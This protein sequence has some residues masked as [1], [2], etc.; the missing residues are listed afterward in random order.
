MAV[1][2][3]ESTKVSGANRATLYTRIENNRTERLIEWGGSYY[4]IGGTTGNLTLTPTAVNTATLQ[5]DTTLSN[6][7]IVYKDGGN[8]YIKDDNN[9]S[10]YSVR[11]DSATNNGLSTVTYNLNVEAGTL[12]GGNSSN[13]E[14]GTIDLNTAR[15]LLN[16]KVQVYTPSSTTLGT[17]NNTPVVYLAFR[18]NNTD[19]IYGYNTG[20]NTLSFIGN[21]LPAGVTVTQ[22]FSGKS[23]QVISDNNGKVYLYADGTVSEPDWQ[24]NTLV[25]VTK[26]TTNGTTGM[27]G[28]I[29]NNNILNTIGGV[30]DSL[31]SSSTI[32][33]NN[34]GSDPQYTV[35]KI[36]YSKDGTWTGLI[37][38]VPEVG[39]GSVLFYDPSTGRL[40]SQAPFADLRASIQNNGLKAELFFQNQGIVPLNDGRIAF[41][42]E[43]SN[44]PV[45]LGLDPNGQPIIQ[46]VNTGFVGDSS[47]GNNTTIVNGMNT[48][49]DNPYVTLASAAAWAPTELKNVQ[50]YVELFASAVLA[51]QSLVKIVN[52]ND[53]NT[54]PLNP[55]TLNPNTL[56]TGIPDFLPP[57]KNNGNTTTQGSSQQTGSSGNDAL[58]TPA[59]LP[60]V[61]SVLA[62]N[63]VESDPE[64]TNPAQ[65]PAASTPAATPTPTPKP[66]PAA[67]TPETKQN[68]NNNKQTVAAASESKTKQTGNVVQNPG[69]GG[70]RSNNNVMAGTNSGNKNEKVDKGTL[71]LDTNDSKNPLEIRFTLDG[72][73]LTANQ[74]KIEDNNVVIQVGKNTGDRI[75]TIPLSGISAVNLAGLGGTLENKYIVKQPVTG[76][77]DQYFTLT[78]A[79]ISSYKLTA[80]GSKPPL[81]GGT[82][83]FDIDGDGKAE[84]TDPINL[85]WAIKN[86][87]PSSSSET[88]NQ[89]KKTTSP[90]E[91]RM[92]PSSP[93]RENFDFFWEVRSPGKK[94]ATLVLMAK[95]KSANTSKPV[96][97]LVK[98]GNIYVKVTVT[99]NA[100]D[101]RKS[102]VMGLNSD[103]YNWD[104]DPQKLKDS[105]IQKEVSALDA[106]VTVRSI[107]VAG[108]PNT[109]TFTGNQLKTEYLKPGA[110]DGN[111]GGYDGVPKNTDIDNLP[112][113]PNVKK[114][115]MV[116]ASASNL[117]QALAGTTFGDSS[118][119]TSLNLNTLNVM[120][121]PLV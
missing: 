30:L 2:L 113:T 87:D 77:G 93:L 32:N 96:D 57:N 109:L 64:L 27:L 39:T 4:L 56:P 40:A 75:V 21:R 28:G 3:T 76:S 81:V 89:S 70:G 103:N 106:T 100:T 41:V 31:G 22:A 51:G 66:K 101:K 71:L 10:V 62:Q 98:D 43:G 85:A 12:G 115:N 18:E 84:N 83:R 80:T 52:G 69:S 68:N 25:L 47:I 86:K 37:A 78:K 94:E 117:T 119:N 116:I 120:E 5:K 29:N 102:L 67:A 73:T 34:R 53:N 11:A 9:G 91:G 112:Y 60:S 61:P 49:L 17:Q 108:G 92:T 16:E 63:T 48:L 38:V 59:P 50:D 110:Y 104:I 13:L 74:F 36:N 97:F 65:T 72:K 15:F 82:K 107:K 8:I 42:S 55:N 90:V 54:A 23:F 121:T 111:G 7:L 118:S 35:Y 19:Q 95:D 58:T 24:N 26:T 46:N 114:E 1:T 99:D 88:P 105:G 20:T 79:G 6:N 45:V 44:Q 14:T 33:T